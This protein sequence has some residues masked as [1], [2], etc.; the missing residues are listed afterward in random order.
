MKSCP[1]CE[2]PLEAKTIQSVEIDECKK[3]KGMWFDKDELRQLKNITDSDLNWLDFDI[4]KH[5]EKLK[6]KVSKISCPNCKAK[7]HVVEYG[8]TGVNIDYCTMCEGVWLDQD[9][10]KKIIDSLEEEL[11]TKSFSEYIQAS[12]KEAKEIVDGPESFMSEWKD[13][14][15]VLRMMKYRLFAEHPKLLNT[16][17]SVQNA[18]PLK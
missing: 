1:V 14:T 13:F 5:K 6:T 2:I 7:P 16:I 8:N 17:T 11:L 12:V 15:T 10:F 18:N 9:K 3:C 4:W